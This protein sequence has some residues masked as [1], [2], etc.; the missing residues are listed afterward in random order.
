MSLAFSVAAIGNH[1][2]LILCRSLRFQFSLS[3]SIVFGS[4]NTVLYKSVGHHTLENENENLPAGGWR[5]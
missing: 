2:I 3:L 5:N 4:I 1:D